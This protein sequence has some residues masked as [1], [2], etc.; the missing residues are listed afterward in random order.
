MRIDDIWRDLDEEESSRAEH[1][2]EHGVTKNE[3][4]EIL[5]NPANPTVTSR[6]SGEQIAFGYA[7]TGRY[8]AVV[9]EQVPEEP[10]TVYPITAYDAPEPGERKS[11]GKRK[12]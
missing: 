8:L 10:F 3:V 1:V 6:S 2:G 12:R 11:K 4:V 5:L 7:S 9:W